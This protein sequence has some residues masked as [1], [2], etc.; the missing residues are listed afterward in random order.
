MSFLL[1]L[2]PP[3]VLGKLFGFLT[4]GRDV[5]GLIKELSDTDSSVRMTAAAMLGNK[6]DRRA[7]EPLIKVLTDSNNDVRLTATLALG[8]LG[9]ARARQPLI[10]ALADTKDEAVRFAISSTLKDSFGWQPDK[11]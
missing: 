3:K 10:E 6:G 11:G 8:Q 7:V 4:A 5:E 9:D 1:R 2:L